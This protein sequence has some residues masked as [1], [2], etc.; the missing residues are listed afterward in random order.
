MNRSGDAGAALDRIS[1]GACPPREGATLP[2]PSKEEPTSASVTGTGRGTS[3]DGAHLPKDVGT[4]STTA[5]GAGLGRNDTGTWPRTPIPVR[6]P[7]DL[8]EWDTVLYGS[9]LSEVLQ[10]IWE[11][12]E[13]PTA[14]RRKPE[15]DECELFYQYNTARC[16]SGRFV[17]RL[18]FLPNRPALAILFVGVNSRPRYWVFEETDGDFVPQYLIEDPKS[19]YE[20]TFLPR[21]GNGEATN[22]DQNLGLFEEEDQSKIRNRRQV[23]TT[24]KIDISGSTLLKKTDTDAVA[25]FGGISGV[26]PGQFDAATA[27]LAY[28]NAK[29]HG[30]SASASHIPTLG[31][32]LTAGGKLNLISTPDHKLDANAF[33][34]RTFT[35]QPQIPDFNTYGGSLDY[36]FHDKLGASL[37][38]KTFPAFDRTDLSAMGKV[39]IFKTP[40]SSFDFGAGYSRTQTPNF[41]FGQPVF[42]MTWSRSW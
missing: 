9:V 27:G 2:T 39:N 12:E 13:P 26:K 37:G 32:T 30:L 5:A 22:D 18:P 11:S 36:T 6:R 25:A 3:T 29:G 38:A 28:E 10:R 34:S 1:E 17:T 33:A 20:E 14:D 16:P 31:N 42:D 35:N 23:K 15:D 24:G 4:I 7:Q 8:P 40:T 19:N 21:C 41:S